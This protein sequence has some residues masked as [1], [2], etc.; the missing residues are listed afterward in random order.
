MNFTRKRMIFSI[1][2]V[3]P[4]ICGTLSTFTVTAATVGTSQLTP[5]TAVSTSPLN[6][7]VKSIAH[8]LR[9]TWTG[10]KGDFIQGDGR[11]IDHTRLDVS[12]SEGESYALLRAAWM[13]DRPEFD[14]VLRWTHDNLQVRKDH[15][16]G[17]LWGRHSD[18]TWSVLSQNTAT[19]AD[20]DIALALVF[21]SKEWGDTSYLAR[22]R[23]VI[24]DIWRYEV[25]HLHGKSY[26]A[27]GNWAPARSNPGPIVNP[28]YFAPYAYRIFA[29]IDPIHPWMQLVST[30]YAVLRDCSAA[31]LSGHAS[32][33]LPPN[34][35]AIDRKT[36]QAVTAKGFPK[37]DIYGYDAFRVM[38]RTALDYQWFHSSQARA[39]LNSSSFLRR[40][41]HVSH[42]LLVQYDHNGHP[43]KGQKDPTFY[44]GD[45]GNFVVV[46]P[47]VARSIVRDKLLPLLRQQNG[48]SFW[49]QRYNYYEQNWVW[50]GVGLAS[51]QLPNLAA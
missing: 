31:L 19:D 45:I 46:A 22:A 51:G 40:Q 17:F 24:S 43:L 11:V 5:A 44:G 42:Q 50:L 25:A 6:L 41:W 36:G 23:A 8:I 10:Y 15:L 3:L 1:A 30:S 48:V 38:W 29:G 20:E 37:A 9:T 4:I 49:D 32:S 16:F 35:C 33:G 26:L 39:Y 13:G 27:A 12:T 7:D 47:S 2:L 18:G 21:A 34:W 28:S 14:L